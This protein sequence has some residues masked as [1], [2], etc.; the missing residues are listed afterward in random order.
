MKDPHKLG[1][2]DTKYWSPLPAVLDWVSSRVPRGGKVLEIGPGYIPFPLADTFVG[3]LG[4]GD[5]FVQCDI[6]QDTLPFAD[7]EFDFVYCRHVLE[8]IY[9]PFLVCREMS[10]VAKAGYL[11]TPSPIAEMCRGIDAGSGQ[12]RGYHH[13]RYFV[14][15]TGGILHFLTK[16]PYVEYIGDAE[17]EAKI[18]EL[19]RNHNLYWNSY[20]FWEGEISTKFH[21][22][23]TDYVISVDYGD[24]IIKAIEQSH[25][26]TSAI[27]EELM[28]F[29]NSQPARDE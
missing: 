19:L 24:L 28:A 3:W 11:E 26:D 7:N 16:Y 1:E 23:E 2:S 13:H 27:G 5:N 17:F 9:N 20:H 10:R 22:H 29:L 21:Q 15:S 25:A 4:S 12:W 14:W 18:T 6:Q 8:D